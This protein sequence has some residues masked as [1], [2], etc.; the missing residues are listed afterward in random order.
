MS[1]KYLTRTAHDQLDHGVT[2][3]GLSIVNRKIVLFGDTISG[4]SGSTEDATFTVGNEV[5]NDFV[6]LDVGVTDAELT[7]LRSGFTALNA[8]GYITGA[9]VTNG[10]MYLRVPD[11]EVGGPNSYVDGGPLGLGPFTTTP[12]KLAQAS[13]FGWAEVG[14]TCGVQL[15]GEGAAWSGGCAVLSLYQL[16]A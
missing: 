1:D 4:A 11:D 3:G 16:G 10:R 9:S 14:D 15:Y 8:S 7:F 6:E 5:N 2:P 12:T 13:W